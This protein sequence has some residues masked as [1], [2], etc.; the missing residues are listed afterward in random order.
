MPHTLPFPNRNFT[1]SPAVATPS[2]LPGDGV[3]IH[4]ESLPSRA[5]IAP[6]LLVRSYVAPPAYDGSPGPLPPTNAGGL[7]GLERG[8]HVSVRMTAANATSVRF[9]LYC[10]SLAGRE[11]K[12]TGCLA[13]A[14]ALFFN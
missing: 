1:L 2:G 3:L 9:R 11:P 6:D 4:A 12:G 7:F 5:A 13:T 10:S 14:S 8:V